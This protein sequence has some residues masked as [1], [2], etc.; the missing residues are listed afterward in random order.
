M[1]KR[2]YPPELIVLP[3]GT[4]V[5]LGLGAFLA[6]ASETIRYAR[7][8]GGPTDQT[9]W[10]GRVEVWEEE[11]DRAHVVP[12]VELELVR[13]VAYPKGV[14]PATTTLLTTGEDGVSDFAL[15]DG[16]GIGA[17]LVVRERGTLGVLAEGEPQLARAA[18]EAAARRRGGGA[19]KTSTG[20]VQLGVEVV[21]P[22]LSVPFRGE[23]RVSASPDVALTFEL[24]GIT[25][26][27][28]LP[29]HGSNEQRVVIPFR[30]DQHA[31]SVRVVGTT[32]EPGEAGSAQ[33]GAPRAK[34]GTWFSSLAVVPGSFAFEQT[35]QGLLVRSPVERERVYF[36]FISA[37]LRSRGSFRPRERRTG[38]SVK[39]IPA[40]DGTSRGSIPKERVEDLLFGHVVLA[41]S[42]DG[43]SPATVGLP[44][45][46]GG[47]T[48]FDV[49][50]GLWLD[51]A[52]RARMLAAR[53][54]MKRRWVL[55]GYG[56]LG[57]V[58]TIA[59]FLLRVRQASRETEKALQRAGAAP[60]VY[61]GDT[62][63][64]TLAVISLFF[65]F[66]LGVLW[67]V[68]R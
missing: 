7:V 57:G 9:T 49:V 56:A 66:S 31:A 33:A 20:E 59:A 37:E 24:E 38:G 3:V 26:L 17:R 54:A 64:G 67:I 32:S 48:T 55:G 13:S 68:A 16:S 40:G 22:V 19:P 61:R 65:A 28:E 41:S 5:V 62:L 43:R 2:R 60:G 12:G 1:G 50:D 6:G 34:T 21:P 8:Y 23:L 63:L 42:V 52:P 15:P 35:D 18:W 36:T 30:T 45:D 58:A 53:D 10:N 27:G 4:V 44:L 11:D 14:A 51:G 47:R 29:T 39:L 46:D 25:P